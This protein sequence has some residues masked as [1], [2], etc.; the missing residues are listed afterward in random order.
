MDTIIIKNGIEFLRWT[1][2]EKNIF[3]AELDAVKFF[4][5]EFFEEQ[6]LDTFIGAWQVVYAGEEQADWDNLPDCLFEY[7]MSNL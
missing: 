1:D 6:P 2:A 4:G 5:K 3:Y 7:A